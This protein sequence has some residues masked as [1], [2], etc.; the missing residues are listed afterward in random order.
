MSRSDDFHG[1]SASIFWFAG[2]VFV[3][4]MALA[5]G[6]AILAQHQQ[7]DADAFYYRVIFTIW[8]CIFLLTPALCFH[9]FS[10]SDGTNSYWRAFWTFAFL[11]LLV[12]LYWAYAGSC[13][14]SA[15]AV[16]HN[17]P[18]GPFPGCIVEHPKP[19]LFLT[20]W[21]GLDVILAW[22]ITDNI[23]WVRVQRGARPSAGFCDVLR[24]FR[25]GRQG[26]HRRPAA[27]HLDGHHGHHLPADT[28]HHQRE[29]SEIAD[30]SCV[31]TR[32][33]Q[34][35]NLIVV[36]HKL[37]TFLALADLAGSPPGSAREEPARYLGYS[38]H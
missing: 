20:A 38:C 14:H 3:A 37:P 33:F 15:D 4:L 24:C 12:H 17:D 32:F 1:S 29:R 13:G 8:A 19:D 31:Y 11:A 7:P 6:G 27:R 16:F 21:W 2:A 35:L 28:A 23:K 36:W 25:A 34:F 10:R 22:L 18:K 9:I 30:S 5:H 26:R